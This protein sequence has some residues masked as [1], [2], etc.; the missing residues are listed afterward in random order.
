MLTEVVNLGYQTPG[1]S[2]QG[3]RRRFHDVASLFALGS[4]NLDNQ[5]PRPAKGALDLQ[6]R[7]YQEIGRSCVIHVVIMEDNTPEILCP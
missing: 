6:P 1:E 3:L 7:G 4:P 5:Q 2:I